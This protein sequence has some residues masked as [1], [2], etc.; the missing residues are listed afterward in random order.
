MP[1]I[2][3]PNTFAA[4]TVTNATLVAENF[5]SPNTTPDTPEVINGQLTDANREAGWDI[6][7]EMIQPRAL[8]GGRAIGSAMPLDFFGVL[9]GGSVLA[10]TPWSTGFV[11]ADWDSS[12]NDSPGLY[13][14]IPGGSLTFYVPYTV[15]VFI[16][17]WQVF[18]TQ[19]GERLG[20]ARQYSVM[21]LFLDG[22]PTA[23]QIR[24][25]PPA[26][27]ALGVGAAR[28][29]RPWDRTWPGHYWDDGDIVTKGWHTLSLRIATNTD[30]ARVQCR[31][32][33]YVY[34]K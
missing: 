17:H 21:K 11:H 20:S 10:G 15:S 18:V 9:D 34:F 5:Y 27:N 25:F 1:D 7:R 16:A 29:G 26:G 14:A 32:L 8:S 13:R 30:V 23:N 4:G 2:T 28:E 12:T 19:A 6:E 31:G 24:T 33:N 22:T 3:I